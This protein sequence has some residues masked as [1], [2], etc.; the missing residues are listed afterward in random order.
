MVTRAAC[1]APIASLSSRTQQEKAPQSLLLRPVSLSLDPSLSY[2]KQSWLLSWSIRP[3]RKGVLQ[4]VCPVYWDFRALQ[5]LP[6]PSR[7]LRPELLLEMSVYVY[8]SM[9]LYLCACM[10]ISVYVCMTD[11]RFVIK[12]DLRQPFCVFLKMLQNFIQLDHFFW[13]YWSPH[14]SSD[15][16]RQCRE[17]MMYL[18]FD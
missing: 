1:S 2:L 8:V 15:A 12:R 7:S 16:K 3:T 13:T 6:F 18:A 5:Y 14:S 9:Y 11:K 17:K 10:F 4:Y